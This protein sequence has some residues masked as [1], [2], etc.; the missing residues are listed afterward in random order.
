MR[1]CV[2]SSDPA[3]AGDRCCLPS[4]APRSKAER[5]RQWPKGPSPLPPCPLVLSR[6]Q[7]FLESHGPRLLRL[8]LL[9]QR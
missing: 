4:P 3:A 8:P 1:G 9:G 5:P 7:L 6:T 2:Q